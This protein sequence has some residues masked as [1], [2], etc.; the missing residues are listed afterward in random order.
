[1]NITVN[2]N[3]IAGPN[4]KPSLLCGVAVIDG[5]AQI[6]EADPRGVLV[7]GALVLF[8]KD[9]KGNE[10]VIELNPDEAREAGALLTHMAYVA[11]GTVPPAIEVKRAPAIEVT[12]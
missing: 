10:V 7:D 4:V 2:R 12:P 8:A 1:M 5:K 9:A 3:I 11:A 6:R